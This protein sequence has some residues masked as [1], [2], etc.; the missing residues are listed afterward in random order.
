MN[1]K[2]A[3]ILLLFLFLSLNCGQKSPKSDKTQNAET[4]QGL[5]AFE[6]EHGIGP[7]TSE[8]TLSE[9]SQ[10]RIDAGQE[11]F[12]IKCSACHKVT[13]R[14]IGPDLGTVLN[15]RSP[16]F[17]L[18]MILN[19]DGMTKEHPE[20]KKMMAEY[21]SP[22]PNQNLTQDEALAIVHYLKSVTRAE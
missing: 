6:L 7:V 18:N 13:E 20:G 8:I 2:I 9:V 21:L 11:L 14:Y 16:T 12:K 15:Q 3:P 19:P 4:P 1:L 10:E 5:T 17:V 22:M